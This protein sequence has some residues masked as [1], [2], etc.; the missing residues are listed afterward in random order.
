MNELERIGRRFKPYNRE[1]EHV[2]VETELLSPL[3]IEKSTRSVTNHLHSVAEVGTD[4]AEEEEEE[5]DRTNL[6]PEGG[7]AV[8][9]RGVAGGGVA[10]VTVES[11]VTAPVAGGGMAVVTV[12]S[13]VTDPVAGGGVAGEGMAIVPV[14]TDPV[15]GESDEMSAPVATSIREE[16]PTQLGVM[17]GKRIEEEGGGEEGRKDNQERRGGEE[18]E[19]VRDEEERGQEERVDVED[20]E[21]KDEVREK[22]G[23][24]DEE[25]KRGREEEEGGGDERRGEDRKGSEER[26]VEEDRESKEES[27]EEEV[28]DKTTEERV[29][30]TKALAMTAPGVKDEVLTLAS[31]QR[32]LSGVSVSSEAHSE[33][34]LSQDTTEDSEKELLQ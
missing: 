18:R 5:S 27:K 19:N 2:A 24:R 1:R 10:V 23:E 20:R 4:A 12:E 26:R 15:A 21:E 3:A 11:G 30:E 31:V 9:E 6:L 22:E 16:Q 13:G 28:K 14:V 32:T 33:R 17:A 7:T 8:V 25:E 34:T 29:E